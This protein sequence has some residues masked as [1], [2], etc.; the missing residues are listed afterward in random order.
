[1]PVCA[2]AFGGGG[3]SGFSRAPILSTVWLYASESFVISLAMAS[4]SVRNSLASDTASGSFGVVRAAFSDASAPAFGRGAAAL[5]EAIE[6]A[7][8]PSRF[9]TSRLNRPSRKV[10]LAKS[11]LQVRNEFAPSPFQSTNCG[12]IFSSSPIL[13]ISAAALDKRSAAAWT[14]PLLALSS[15]ALICSCD[16]S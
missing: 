1:M 7:A 8:S 12:R 16:L 11:A 2:I 5:A 6:S 3:N 9:D 10:A 15:H 4:F 14:A 13:S